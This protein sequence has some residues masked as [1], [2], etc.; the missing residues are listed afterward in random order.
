MGDDAGRRAR[1]VRSVGGAAIGLAS[2]VGLWRLV[3]WVFSSDRGL[4]FRDEGLYL[5]AADPPSPTARWVTPFGWHTAPFF[6]IVGHD[7]AHLRTFAVCVLV[8]VG[9]QLGWV[10]GRRVTDGDTDGSARA[11]R[12][13]LAAV[14]AFGA[15]LLT[16]GL[17]RTP[18]YN[19][20]NLVGLL[21]ATTGAVMAVTMHDEGSWWRSPR[22]HAAA[23]VL[24]LGLW[25]TVPA[26]PSSAPLFLVATAV[27]LAP[28]LRRRT[29][30]FAALTAA[31]G[32]GWTL[33]G[34]AVGWWPVDFLRVLQQSA[35][36]P[37]LDRNQTIPGAFLDVLRTPKV[38]WK[39]LALLRPA[40]FAL[41]IVAAVIALVARRRAG[42][43]RALRIAPLV[44]ATVAAV[45]TAVPWPLLGLPNP[46]VRFD[47]YG[48][49]NAGV[50]LFIGALLHLLANWRDTDRPALARGLAIGGLCVAG[51][52]IFGFGSAMSIYHQAAL[53]ASL[54]WCAT[55]ALVATIGDRR[56]RLVAL[57]ITTV[58]S[59]ALLVSNV[60]D[61][62]HHPFDVSAMAEQTTP[63]RFG[64]HDDELVLDPDT[65]AYVDAVQ[66]LADGAGFCAGDPLIGMVWD[67]TATESFVLGATAPE[68]FIL[69]IFG[70]PDA[71]SVLDVTMDD[72]ADPQ[73]HDA[74]LMTTDPIGLEADD[75]AELRA[76]QDRLPDVVGR[77]FPD[78][79][80]IVGN[81][82]GTQ[83][84]RPAD[85]G[86]AA[87]CDDRS[88]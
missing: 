33:F 14:G 74:W 11:V 55:A 25:F 30:S 80:T 85:P 61:S 44:I 43:G 64:A 3:A 79:Y 36:F 13:G 53:A 46:P 68:H 23:A 17:L 76:A 51:V 19:W 22:A 40:T 47:W 70:Y 28:V 66:Q 75:A 88:K 32:L 4:G 5:L 20:V 56:L 2:L 41:M 58:A 24:A 10:I 1:L 9:A 57:G 6:S 87:T 71:A 7:V 26:K 63:T 29:W 18:G 21:V 31:W 67:W 15:P 77:T 27:F 16:S 59:F 78:D 82:D 72:L 42:S 39:D 52:F 69:T 37:P 86:A 60:V 34:I 73:W 81:V 35:S 83:L 84:W 65:A 48:T 49:T 12:F 38:A 54:M 50:L 62:R 8:V 45:G